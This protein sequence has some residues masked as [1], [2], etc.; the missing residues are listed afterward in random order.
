MITLRNKGS[1]KNSIRSHVAYVKG[2]GRIVY[3]Q[4]FIIMAMP[5]LALS[6]YH[7]LDKLFSRLP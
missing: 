2:K 3:R 4:P 7:W 1:R 5:T 6:D